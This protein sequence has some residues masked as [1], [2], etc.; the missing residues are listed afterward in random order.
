MAPTPWAT[1]E[2]TA[3]LQAWLPIYVQ[4]QAEQKLSLFWPSMEEAWFQKYPEQAALDLPLPTDQNK[5]ALEPEERVKLQKALEGRKGQL[6]NWFR[7][8]CKKMGNP[9]ANKAMVERI[10]RFSGGPKKRRLHHAIELF[11]TRNPELI[12]EALTKAGYDLLNSKQDPDEPDDWTDES[13]DTPEARTKRKKSV[14]MRVRTRVIRDLFNDA[15]EEELAAIKEDLETPAGNDFEAC[16]VEFDKNVIQPFQDFLRICFGEEDSTNWKLPAL[17]EPTM[18]DTPVLRIPVT[19]PA[20]EPETTTSKKSKSKKSKKSMSDSK[21]KKSKKSN[22]TAAVTVSKEDAQPM[23]EANNSDGESLPPSSRCVSPDAAGDYFDDASPRHDDDMADDFT[24]TAN[25]DAVAPPSSSPE[26]TSL[27]PPSLWP[28]GMTAPLPP[29]VAETIATLERGGS[30]NNATMAID[31]RLLEPQP[32]DFTVTPTPPPPKTRPTY[33]GSGF[34]P[35]TL[36][37]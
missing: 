23:I 34:T 15:S 22:A 19:E 17:L 13:A 36:G 30:S 2:Q 6:A 24:Q 25:A 9:V 37:G 32:L 1:P 3:F 11:Q 4:R 14:R 28:A 12:K 16:C 29:Q 8:H 21:S 5:R 7:N 26:T 20:P 33:K 31:P 35:T 10:F 27:T 18:D